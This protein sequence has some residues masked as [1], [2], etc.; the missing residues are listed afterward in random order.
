MDHATSLRFSFDERR[1]R[2]V[3]DAIGVGVGEIDDDRSGA[4]V[5][6]ERGG[7]AVDGGDDGGS[8]DSDDGGRHDVDGSD[9]ARGSGDVEEGAESAVVVEID[10]A[11]LVALRASCNS[12]T[13]LVATAERVSEAGRRYAAAAESR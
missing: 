12:W 3:A 13:R 5:S 11:D 1:A 6:R 4:A 7:E 9:G 8:H 2:V 10:A